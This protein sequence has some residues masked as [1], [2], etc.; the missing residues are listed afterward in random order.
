MTTYLNLAYYI[1]DSSAEIDCH[2]TYIGH[3]AYRASEMPHILDKNS[4]QK[5]RNSL[6]VIEYIG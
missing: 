2:C 3:N 4:K 1:S 5:P 6:Q